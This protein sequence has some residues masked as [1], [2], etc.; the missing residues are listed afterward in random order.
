MKFRLLALIGVLLCSAAG[1][2]EVSTLFT[3]QVPLDR[4]QQ[5]PRN[6]AYRAALAQVVL[7]VSGSELLGDKDLYAALFP[8]PAA[9]VVQFRPGPDD[10]LFVSFDGEALEETLRQA[11]QTV[12]GADRPLT[13]VWLAVDW[14]QGER[15]ILG[16]NDMD[17]SPDEG[18]SV[19]LNR[20]LRQ[21]LLDF[22][23]RRG[24]PIMFPLLDSEDLAAVNFSDIWGGFDEALLEASARYD[25][26][27]V[28]IGRVRAGGPQQNRWSYYFGPEQRYWSGE[29]EIVV[30]QIADM[31]AAEFAIRGDAPL[32]T[33]E[34]NVS[35]VTTV[36]AYGSVQT[37]LS[38][39]NLI[40]KFAIVAVNGDT[41]QYRV[42]VHGGAERL[43][44]ALRFAGL[45][46]QE[47]IDSDGYFSQSDSL[48]F[49]FD[50]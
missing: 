14:G 13:L 1:S 11:G 30:M 50:Q 21:R 18:R 38:E 39:V 16:A 42:N 5:N 6:E 43:A 10:T 34:L 46:E 40:D 47:R 35:G 4:Q 25:V 23:E 49:F 3:A 32:R 19:D 15:E 28:L 41:I 45:V 26:D 12:W 48:D 36:D 9:Y 24:L 27:S 20:M 2:V 22:A 7:R 31:L 17:K 8:N 29:P 37:L 33:V 44:R